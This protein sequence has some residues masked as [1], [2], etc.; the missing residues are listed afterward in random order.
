MKVHPISHA[1]FETTRSGFIQILCHCAVSL[2]VAPPYLLVQTLIILD[3][4][5][6]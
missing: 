6:P 3:K 2:K 5:S 1:I 4:N